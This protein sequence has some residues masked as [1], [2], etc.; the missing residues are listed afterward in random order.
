MEPEGIKRNQ[1]EYKSVQ[2]PC[3]R[4]SPTWGQ[5]E[6][7]ARTYITL[8]RLGS[9][10]QFASP[11]PKIFKEIR[12]LKRPVGAVFCFPA[13]PD[14]TGEAWGKQQKANGSARS[15][16]FGVPGL[17]KRSIR[18]F[19]LTRLAARRTSSCLLAPNVAML[20]SVEEPVFHNAKSRN[21]HGVHPCI[22]APTNRAGNR[23]K[24][25]RPNAGASMQRRIESLEKP[26]RTLGASARSAK[27][28]PRKPSKS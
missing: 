17:A 25:M 11:A 2:N 13:S 23:G 10:V 22:I 12:C 9:G 28:P 27:F 1:T 18:V 24:W 7:S 14:K 8:P 4:G 5:V 3:T 26:S 20:A 21:R 6:F 16:T 15:D 19:R